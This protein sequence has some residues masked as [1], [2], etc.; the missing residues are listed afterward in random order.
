[1]SADATV[2]SD[3]SYAEV[4]ASVEASSNRPTLIIADVTRDDAWLSMGQ[5]DAPALDDWR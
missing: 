1:M 4:M 2:P 3:G 5:T